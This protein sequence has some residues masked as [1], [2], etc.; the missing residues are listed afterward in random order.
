MFNSAVRKSGLM[1]TIPLPFLI[2]GMFILGLYA[3]T[4]FGGEFSLSLWGFYLVFVSFL[5]L[6]LLLRKDGLSSYPLAGGS[7]LMI[8][9]LFAATLFSPFPDYRWGGLLPYVPLSILFL[10]NLRDLSVGR[11]FPAIL[12]VANLINVFLGVAAILQN[13]R[14]GD[15]LIDHYS[16]GYSELVPFM[17]SAGK[18]VL[19]FGTHSVAAL[20]Y[21]MLFLM[22]FEA[23]KVYRNWSSLFFAFCYVVLG[24][25]LRSVSG[26]LLMF[27]ATL[28]FLRYGFRLRPKLTAVSLI[29]VIAGAFGTLYY[30]VPDFDDWIAGGKL[31]WDILTSPVNG[32][33]GRFTD[34]G[35]LYSTVHYIQSHPFS[36]VGAGYR[37]DLMFGDSGPVEYYLR[38]SLLLLAAVYV[39]LFFFLRKNLVSL[40]HS[41]LL[42]LVILAFETGYSSMIHFRTLFLL[43]VL[44]I[45]LNDLSRET[46]YSPAARLSSTVPVFGT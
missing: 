33:M 39:G 9:T 14:I 23:H 42:F 43:P 40:G 26:L 45:F 7:I 4:S 8:A 13:A 2:G 24:F 36:P 27:F 5:L 6:L 35:T 30:I 10:V 37:G 18:P 22:N 25:A 21:Y 41:R 28:Q 29:T 44:I 11:S 20:F 32:F 17:M 3:P 46:L 38:G 15:F 34:I 31:V 19:T 12:W 1:E 16:S